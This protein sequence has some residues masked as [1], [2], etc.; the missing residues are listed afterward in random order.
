MLE[1]LR[2]T[3]LGA[4][5]EVDL[6]FDAGLTVLTGETG[7]GK[8]LLVEALHLVLGGSD[9]GVPVREPSAPSRVEAI[10]TTPGGELVLARERT[11]G[12]RLRALVDGHLSSAPA[13]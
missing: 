8:T 4:V 9:R 11:A 1:T 10:F 6:E 2:I 7:V 12:G 3:N 5:D 13:L